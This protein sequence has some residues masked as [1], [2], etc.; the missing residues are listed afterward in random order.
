[1]CWNIKKNCKVLLESKH[2]VLI[3]ISC[4]IFRC[5]SNLWTNMGWEK[6]GRLLHFQ[7]KATWSQLWPLFFLRKLHHRFISFVC[8]SQF[9]RQ[10]FQIQRIELFF[11]KKKLFLSKSNY[12]IFRLETRAR[13][14]TEAWVKFDFGGKVFQAMIVRC[15]GFCSWLWV[16]L[17]L[18]NL[19]DSSSCVTQ[20]AI[21][22]SAPSCLN[23][24]KHL[25]ACLPAK[26]QKLFFLP[27][28]LFSYSPNWSPSPWQAKAFNPTAI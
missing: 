19:I 11:Y 6:Q 2:F 22:A 27:A 23:N 21:W 25:M 9:R 7:F 26:T 17:Q 18:L 28:K 10:D 14:G 16:H 15:I 24:A 1:M 12:L 8:I 20:S 13:G 3:F 4:E 5:S